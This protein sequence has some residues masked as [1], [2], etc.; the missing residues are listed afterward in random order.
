MEHVF[1]LVEVVDI[2]RRY[3]VLSACQH[4]LRVTSHETFCKDQA[5]REELWILDWPV[6]IGHL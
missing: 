6:T 1:A 2:K 5:D 4:C 3:I